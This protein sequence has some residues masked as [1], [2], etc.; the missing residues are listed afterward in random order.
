MLLGYCWCFAIVTSHDRHIAFSTEHLALDR[1]DIVG[2][3]PTSIGALTNLKELNL[4]ANKM[5]G[6]IPTELLNL[7]DLQFLELSDNLF[8][9][10]IPAGLGSLTDLRKYQ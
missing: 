10:G 9:G 4:E 8:S 5:T 7:V 6:V 2:P 3:I 1:N